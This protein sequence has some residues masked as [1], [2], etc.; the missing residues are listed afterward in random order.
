MVKR[1]TK[2]LCTAAVTHIHADDVTSA[3]PKLIGVAN[4]ILRVR[5]AFETV[6]DDGRR[7]R[8]T[9]IRRLPMTIASHLARDLVLSR[10]RYLYE[11]NFRRRKRIHACKEVA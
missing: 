7:S 4:D 2:P 5:G 8:R 6:H 10:W 11:L 1:R 9:D 3:L